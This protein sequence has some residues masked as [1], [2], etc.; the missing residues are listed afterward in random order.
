MPATLKDRFEMVVASEIV[1]HVRDPRTFLSNALQMA[2]PRWGRLLLSTQSGPL[3]ETERRVGHLRHFAAADMT[4]VLL[5]AGWEPLRVWN[6]GFPFH[7][8]SKW[9]ANRDPDAS[10]RRFGDERYGLREDLVCMA[11]RVAFRLNSRRR[12]AQ[13]FALARRP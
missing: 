7:D 4:Q 8:L 9:Y 5:D 6:A 10:M 3:R 1:E 12:G 2:V 11:L 13:L